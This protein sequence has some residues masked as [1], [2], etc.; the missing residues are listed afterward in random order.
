M[1]GTALCP[2]RPACPY[3]AAP[4][5]PAL[6]ASPERTAKLPRTPRVT[7][8]TPVGTRA[9]APCSPWTSSSA[10]APEDGQVARCLISSNVFCQKGTNAALFYF[11]NLLNYKTGQDT[12]CHCLY[13]FACIHIHPCLCLLLIA[14]RH[15]ALML[16]TCP[17]LSL[18]D[19]SVSTRTA[20]YRARAPT[21]DRAALCLVASTPAHVPLDTQ[22]LAALMTQMNVPPHL[23]SAKT[24]EYA[25]TPLVLTSEFPAE[26][27]KRTCLFPIEADRN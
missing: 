14:C 1:E 12:G 15:R 3:P 8:T 27:S 16:H 7:P 20:A 18:Q 25:S 10:T 11:L 26:K 17:S 23:P 2:C 13:L 6:L 5:A 4:P 19:H 9:S 24:M 21:V 22:V